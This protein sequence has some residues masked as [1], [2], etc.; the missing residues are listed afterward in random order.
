[1]WLA[2]PRCGADGFICGIE[3]RL[4]RAVIFWQDFYYMRNIFKSRDHVGR[5]P[6]KLQHLKGFFPRMV[7][8]YSYIMVCDGQ[9][10]LFRVKMSQ[11]QHPGKTLT[12]RRSR[13]TKTL[14]NIFI[15]NSDPPPSLL[16]DRAEE[17][18]PI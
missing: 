16:R 15:L 12:T 8:D 11:R 7:S 18:G 14:L 2:T 1:M 3:A 5:F 13:F 9:K 4:G 17:E 6:K 10:K